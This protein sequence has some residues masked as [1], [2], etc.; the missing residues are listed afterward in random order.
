M[1]NTEEI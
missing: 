1:N